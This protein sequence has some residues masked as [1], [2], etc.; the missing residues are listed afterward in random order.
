MISAQIEIPDLQDLLKDETRDIMRLITFGSASLMK[1][2][3]QEAKSGRF[4]K[5]GNL[6][7]AFSKKRDVAGFKSYTTVKG[8]TRQIVG[9]KLHQ[10]SAPGQAP[11]NDSSNLVNTIIPDVKDLNG[12]ITLATYGLALEDGAEGTGR[13][14]SGTIAPRPF[15]VPSIEEILADL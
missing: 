5:R 12:E 8:N 11:A 7:A 13:S 6:T 1:V 3:I 14:G 9:S 15:I 2:K 4:Y 10:A